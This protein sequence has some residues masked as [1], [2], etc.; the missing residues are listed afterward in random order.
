MGSIQQNLLIMRSSWGPTAIFR[1]LYWKADSEGKHKFFAWLLVESKILTA[2]KLMSKHWPCNP[3]CS[4]CNNDQETAEHLVLHCNFARQVWEKMTDWSQQLVQPPQ[5]GIQI[6][7]WWEKELA[8][9]PKK[10]R[11]IKAAMMMYC[12][13]N[14]WKERNR[15]VFE[16]KIKEPGG[17]DPRDQT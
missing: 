5:N 10:I 8:H 13:W 7:D 15:R 17:S 1:A 4:L 3:I 14:L 6:L 12:A 16:Q 11:K 9:L 2:D